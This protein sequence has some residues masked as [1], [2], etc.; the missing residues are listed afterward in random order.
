MEID[1]AVLLILSVVL[2]IAMI[3]WSLVLRPYHSTRDLVDTVASLSEQVRDANGR[4]RE[5]ET[6]S[7]ADRGVVRRIAGE[8][9]DLK[10]DFA[11]LR[12]GA[13]RLS[14]QVIESGQ[15]PIWQMPRKFDRWHNTAVSPITAKEEARAAYLALEGTFNEDETRELAFELGT[16]YE[17]LGGE[18]K[19]ARVQS[20]VELAQKSGRLNELISLAKSKR[21]LIDWLGL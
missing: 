14:Q 13:T 18:T 21:P 3:A 1:N 2:V 12:A 17:N 10:Y 7:A 9:T 11:E 16:D 6:E 15:V 19:R 20:L 4:I 8:L 5:L